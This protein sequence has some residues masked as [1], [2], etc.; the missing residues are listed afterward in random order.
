[1]L[2]EN[3]LGV[4]R[5]TQTLALREGDVCFPQAGEVTAGGPSVKDTAKLEGKSLPMR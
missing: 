2:P 4:G 1:M 5:E 3:E